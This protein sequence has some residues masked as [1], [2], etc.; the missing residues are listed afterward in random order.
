LQVFF[1]KWR[2]LDATKRPQPIMVH[3]NYHP[4]KELRMKS[5]IDFFNTGNEHSIMKWPG[6]SAPGT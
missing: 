6:G 3:I 2:H 5:I 1:K 4:D